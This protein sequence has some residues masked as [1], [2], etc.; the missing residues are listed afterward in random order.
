MALDSLRRLFA[1]LGPEGRT[2]GPDVLDEAWYRSIYPLADGPSGARRHYEGLGRACGYFPNP[3]RARAASPQRDIEGG[4]GEAAFAEALIAA[5][6]DHAA[7]AAENGDLSGM[8]A[9]ELAAHYDRH[10]RREGR[11]ARFVLPLSR[12]H[13]AA[14]RLGLDDAPR[15]RLW[16]DLAAAALRDADRFGRDPAVFAEL[17]A[18]TDAYRPFVVVSDSHGNVYL[19][20]QVLRRA[21]LLPVPLM[22]DAG[23][24]RG[25]ANPQARSGH[26]QKILGFLEGQGRRLAGVSVV[27]K[28]GQVDLEFVHD[29]QRIRDGHERFD[30]A[31]AEAFAAESARRYAGFAAEAQAACAGA[32]V[33]TAAFPPVL[34]DEALR[35]GYVNAK[36]A[37]FN[38]DREEG[39]VA[40]ALARL[41]MPGRAARSALAR[42]FNR[43]LAAA[44]AEAGVRFFDDASG[45]EG[46]DGVLDP[47][48]YAS[49]G[50]RDHHMDFNGPACRAVAAPLAERICAP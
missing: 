36:I 40:A 12:A 9:L 41:E 46:P 30:L 31:R 29:F 32:V 6:F 28:F 1:R 43:A 33:V 13:A 18:P 44:C 5:G 45:L 3:A 17:L 34:S 35:Q 39:D 50:G 38:A 4:E 22:C 27:L 37:A 42:R 14:A 25:L 16:L 19:D 20:E 23:S 49:H 8:T 2:G 15:R 10:G 7:Y 47:A 11:P 26:R 48:F 24:A 21:R